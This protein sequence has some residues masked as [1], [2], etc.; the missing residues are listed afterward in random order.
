[1][2][3][4][5]SVWPGMADV[6]PGMFSSIRWRRRCSSSRRIR[7]EEVRY[8][9]LLLKLLKLSGLKLLLLKLLKLFGFGF[10]LG[11]GLKL[12]PLLLL[13]LPLLLLLLLLGVLLK[14]EDI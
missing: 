14:D 4:G 6:L 9:L 8:L 10:G 13:L 12:F 5:R 1:M 7:W 2:S 11:L 3:R